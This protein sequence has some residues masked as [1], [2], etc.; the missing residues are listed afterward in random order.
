MDLRSAQVHVFLNLDKGITLQASGL[1]IL[2]GRQEGPNLSDFISTPYA[3]A[4]PPINSHG[5]DIPHGSHKPSEG[6]R[7]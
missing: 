7:F 5:A 2:H 4:L 1:A 3:F 6:G